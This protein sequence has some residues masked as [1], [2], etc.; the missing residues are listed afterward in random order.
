[1]ARRGLGEVLCA[2]DHASVR[3]R[4]RGRVDET[5]ARVPHHVRVA[6]L[7]TPS[8]QVPALLETYYTNDPHYYAIGSLV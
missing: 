7:R 8:R 1:M 5:L 3:G 4:R 2:R 6:V